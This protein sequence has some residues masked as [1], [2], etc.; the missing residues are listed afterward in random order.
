MYI[1]GHCLICQIGR[2]QNSKISKSFSSLV[3][4]MYVSAFFVCRGKCPLI[5]PWKLTR[6]FKHGFWFPHISVC[7]VRFESFYSLFMWILK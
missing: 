2:G 5:C 4:S 6:N 1:M 3:F 7:E